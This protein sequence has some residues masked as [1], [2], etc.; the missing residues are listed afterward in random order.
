MKNFRLV[1]QSVLVALLILTPFKALAVSAETLQ[2]INFDAPWYDSRVTCDSGSDTANLPVNL[3]GN[4]N[5]EKAF[6]FFVD[7]NLTPEQSAAM[8]GNLQQESGVNPKSHQ[9]GG[10]AGRGIAQWSVDGRWPGVVNFA[11][12][13]GKSEWELDVQLEYIWQE[14]HT[15][16]SAALNGLLAA[17]TIEDMV[18]VI[19][20]KYEVAGKPMMDRRIT[21]AKNVLQLYGNS[22]TTT[23]GTASGSVYMVGDS[24]TDGIASAGIA[25]TLKAAGWQPTTIDASWGRSIRGGGT[26][27]NNKKPAMDAI[28][29]DQA[30]IKDAAIIY[31]GLGTNPSG[32]INQTTWGS[33]IDAFID[34]IRSYNSTAP[35]Y[36]L[37]VISPVI[38]DKDTRN[39]TLSEHAKTKSFKIIDANGVVSAFGGGLHPK[40]YGPLKDYVAKALATAQVTSN[41]SESSLCGSDGTVGNGQDT[42]FIDGFAIYKQTDPAWK[43]KPYGSSTI[44]PSGCGPSAMAMIVTALTGNKVTPPEVAD[45]A[46]SMYV[47]GAGSSWQIGPFVAQ[48]YGLQS[49]AV[50]ASVSKI[51]EALLA[52][53]LVV[54]PGDGAD[55]FTKGGHYI[56]IRGV[57]ASGKWKIGDSKGNGAETSQKEWDPQTLVSQMHSGGVYA[58][59][60]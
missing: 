8:I 37:N 32:S 60:K 57:T 4:D 40:D 24:I 50:G 46:K 5:I 30:K 14:L 18:K 42:K 28:T 22:V 38:P 13:Q 52:G 10:G 35:I 1:A 12:S 26:T 31:V 43:N 59:S 6:R 49:S 33:D 15:G 16:Y 23:N 9:E 29:D 25:D 17:T 36:W 39:A 54:A 27:G 3:K 51:T 58:I 11:K 41:S 19:S 20:T 48:H 21:Y 53:G 34:K 44:G 7:K 45:V 55:P 47:E 2:G 56:V